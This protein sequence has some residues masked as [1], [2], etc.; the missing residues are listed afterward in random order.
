MCWNIFISTGF[1]LELFL[2]CGEINYT[3]LF[4]IVFK[5]MYSFRQIFMLRFSLAE[6]CLKYFLNWGYRYL[7]LEAV[8]SATYQIQREVQKAVSLDNEWRALMLAVDK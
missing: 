8:S 4:G 3:S 2:V 7:P 6:K 1:K 5:Q